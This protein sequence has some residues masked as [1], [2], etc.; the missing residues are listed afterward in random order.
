[1]TRPEIGRR[2]DP[3][4]RDWRD[5]TDPPGS[6][7]FLAGFRYRKPRTVPIHSLDPID[8]LSPIEHHDP[9]EGFRDDLDQQCV[10]VH[11]LHRRRRGDL[12]VKF[13]AE[14]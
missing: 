1:M 7:G 12:R 6:G 14:D 2:R 5:R 9:P 10:A 13:C 8:T 4:P 3:W 11:A